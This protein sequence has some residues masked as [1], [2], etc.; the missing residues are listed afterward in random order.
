MS[1]QEKNDEQAA[2]RRQILHRARNMPRIVTNPTTYN[3]IYRG[4]LDEI[5]CGEC[6]TD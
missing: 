3:T 4:V 6:H 1:E 5:K 2:L